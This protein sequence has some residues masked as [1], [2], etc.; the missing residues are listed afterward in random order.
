MSTEQDWLDGL[1]AGDEVLVERGEAL[2]QF[3][4]QRVARRTPSRLIVL[5][6]GRTFKSNGAHRGAV[7]PLPSLYE[8]TV[9]REALMRKLQIAR[10]LHAQKWSTL[11]LATLE[12]VTA[13]LN[14]GETR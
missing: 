6:D 8:P 13:A 9:E 10:R 5:D 11:S 4:R 2:T 14:E 12:R 7:Y 3:S 1:K